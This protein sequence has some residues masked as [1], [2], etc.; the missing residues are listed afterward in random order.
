MCSWCAN[1]SDP[2]ASTKRLRVAEFCSPSAVTERAG[3]ET[4][5][6]SMHILHHQIGRRMPHAGEKVDEVQKAPRARIL[7]VALVAISRER[8]AGR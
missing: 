1:P 8:L 5:L 3:A 7:I 6:E 4:N 2:K